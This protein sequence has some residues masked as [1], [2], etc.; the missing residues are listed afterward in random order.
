MLSFI[1][2]FL[3]FKFNIWLFQGPGKYGHWSVKW[4]KESWDEYFHKLGA[5]QR[6]CIAKM[7]SEEKCTRC[8]KNLAYINEKRRR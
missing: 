8:S 3:G 2:Y 4:P 1:V 5:K 6:E 7:K